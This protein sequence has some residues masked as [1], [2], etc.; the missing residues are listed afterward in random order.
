MTNW[1]P[2]ELVALRRLIAKAESDPDF[3]KDDIMNLK[4]LADAFRGWQYLGRFTKWL[5]FLLAALAGAIAAY[6]TIT[7]KVQ[8]WL[9]A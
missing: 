4:Q 9:G 5:I 2:S 6:E 8:T 7:I 3:T 1:T